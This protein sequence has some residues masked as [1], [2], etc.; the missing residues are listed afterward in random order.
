M[1]IN[2][3][4]LCLLCPNN[5]SAAPQKLKKKKIQQH[6]KEIQISSTNRTLTFFV[7]VSRAWTFS[8]HSFCHLSDCSEH[9]SSHFPSHRW[10]L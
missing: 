8:Q 3:K 2:K 10:T 9:H 1:K 7:P 4:A 6:P 5:Q